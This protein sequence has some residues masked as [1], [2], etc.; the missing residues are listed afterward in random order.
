MRVDGDAVMKCYL[1]M[2]PAELAGETV[3]L[4]ELREPVELLEFH[5]SEPTADVLSL[6][7]DDEERLV[8]RCSAGDLAIRSQLWAPLRQRAEQ[9]IEI[10]L[11][12]QYSKPVA[13][14]WLVEEVKRKL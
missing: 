10:T 3:W 7:C 14:L 9:T 8:H 6:R 12:G 2:P 1:T 11:R 4:L 5:F 13:P